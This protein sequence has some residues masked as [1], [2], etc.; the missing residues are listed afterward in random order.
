MC[1]AGTTVGV[2]VVVAGQAS[3]P[4]PFAVKNPPCIKYIN[5]DHGKPPIS[6]TITGTGFGADQQGAVG[7]ILLDGVA[8]EDINIAG[9]N[10]SDTTI[11][12][13]FPATKDATTPWPP[14]TDVTIA[15]RTGDYQ[16]NTEPFV[17][18]P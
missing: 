8:R 6:V 4:L 10:W 14:N 15:V 3:D 16:S 1:E 5:P 17:I 2:A 13:M 11:T 7:A 9:Q 12:F 18:L